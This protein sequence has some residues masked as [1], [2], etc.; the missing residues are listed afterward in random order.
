MYDGQTRDLTK[1]SILALKEPKKV[2]EDISAEVISQITDGPPA[3]EKKVEAP[4][5]DLPEPIMPKK[6]KFS[7]EIISFCIEKTQLCLNLKFN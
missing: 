2:E 1:Y 6:T 4:I 3:I 7:F 5:D